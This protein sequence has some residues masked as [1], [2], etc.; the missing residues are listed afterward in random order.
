M[1]RKL[2]YVFSQVLN[3]YKTAYSNNGSFYV[4]FGVL[5]IAFNV[6]IVATIYFFNWGTLNKLS[7]LPIDAAYIYTY[8]LLLLLPCLSILTKEE[9]E[10][11][12]LWATLRQNLSNVA[13]LIILSLVGYFLMGVYADIIAANNF[14]A[15][16][17]SFTGILGNILATFILV[18]LL[19]RTVQRTISFIGVLV[20]SIVLTI[21]LM[22]L[23]REFYYFVKYGVMESFQDTFRTDLGEIVFV[24]ILFVMVNMIISP[25]LASI[26]TAFI[27]YEKT[28]NAPLEVP[29]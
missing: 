16:I 19:R 4:G 13:I 14:F 11:M 22:G 6:A 2:N 10:E 20:E 3:T 18:F 27:R 26:I 24:P 25:L 21:I 29:L 5:Y 17:D 9:G 28:E 15:A 8:I 23:I 7:N 1:N 12:R